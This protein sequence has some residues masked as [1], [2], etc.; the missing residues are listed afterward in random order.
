M[1][2]RKND[3]YYSAQWMVMRLLDVIHVSGRIL[4]PC[5]GDGAISEPLR[6]SGL[7]V[8]TNDIDDCVPTDTHGDY[9]LSSLGKFDWIIT[10]PPFSQAFQMLVKA[11]GETDR[12]VAFQLRLSFLEPTKERVEW[13]HV[14]PPSHL[15]VLPRY[16]FTGD[17][18]SD[19]VTTAWMVWEH[20][21]TNSGIYISNRIS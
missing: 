20:D 10:N 8:S 15:I 19:S 4:E 5:V 14:N 7:S 13:L 6:A 1:K 16:S 21:S 9:L 3:A 17:G 18:K 11:F 2:R 12:G